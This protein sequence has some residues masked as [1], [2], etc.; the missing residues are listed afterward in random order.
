[1]RTV[2]APGVKKV[3][4]TLTFSLRCEQMSC[5]CW[6]SLW[7]SSSSWWACLAS[8]RVTRALTSSSLWSRCHCWVTVL[9]CSWVKRCQSHMR[10]CSIWRNNMHDKGIYMK[11]ISQNWSIVTVP[12]SA[13]NNSDMIP[14][15]LWIVMIMMM[16]MIAIITTVLVGVMCKVTWGCGK[17][18][19][20]LYWKSKKNI[21]ECI[22]LNVFQL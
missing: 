2:T 22:H 10:S 17:P 19:S 5:W 15:F 21:Q 3:H 11:D 14:E 6:W 1:M 18:H 20:A 16:K 13:N 8:C 7:S 4:H 9:S 12:T